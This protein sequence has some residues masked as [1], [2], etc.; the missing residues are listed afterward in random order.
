MFRWL[1]RKPEAIPAGW[2]RYEPL[3]EW[4]RI[5]I[6]PD[7]TI[8]VHQGFA[9]LADPGNEAV[10]GVVVGLRGS[11]TLEQFAA[12]SFRLEEF[13]RPLAEA[14]SIRGNGWHEGVLRDF[15]GTYP[16][17]TEE[18]FRRV[19]C[20]RNRDLFAKVSFYVDPS[21]LKGATYSQIV[22]SIHLEPIKFI[23]P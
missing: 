2:K 20:V 14:S 19:V 11:S 23:A 4:F 13:M 22:T 12:T 6:P 7:W 17:E 3:R 1:R 8:K 10:V 18:S 15:A 21:W 9:T 16:D 5:A